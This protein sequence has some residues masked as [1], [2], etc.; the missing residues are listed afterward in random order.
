MEQRQ[1]RI[2]HMV[3]FDLRHEEG[4]AEEARFLEDGMRI[5]TS[6]PVVR[7][8]GAFRQTSAKNDYRFGFSME[9][10]SQADYDAYNAH[11]AHV[12]FV[13]E[14]WQAEVSRFL[15]IDFD[16]DG[17]AGAAD[18]SAVL[19]S[20]RSVDADGSSSAGADEASLA[21]GEATDRSA[22]AGAARDRS[23]RPDGKREEAGR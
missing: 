12:S 22:A 1:G 5:L 18:E 13:E 14:R 3:I 11:P 19:R 15:E 2:R 10:D 8:F 9:F 20:D 4:S 23:A 17:A 6:I 21:A 16:L 7:A